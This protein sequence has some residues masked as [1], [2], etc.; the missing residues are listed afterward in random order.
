LYGSF[1]VNKQDKVFHKVKI[2]NSGQVSLPFQCYV[3]ESE[4]RIAL[5]FG[6]NGFIFTAYY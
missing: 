3:F 6:N 4:R 5:F 2:R 1:A